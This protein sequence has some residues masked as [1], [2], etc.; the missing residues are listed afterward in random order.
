MKYL[1]LSRSRLQ[2][3]LDLRVHDHLIHGGQGQPG[4]FDLGELGYLVVGHADRLCLPLLP[5]RKHRAPGRQPAL[6]LGV[7]R[8]PRHAALVDGLDD[9]RHR[10]LRVGVMDE[11]EVDPGCA[12][13]AETVPLRQKRSR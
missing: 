9:G 5:Q 3:L 1:L 7:D 11:Q 8:R 2:L 12:L 10:R 6:R 13:W 4:R